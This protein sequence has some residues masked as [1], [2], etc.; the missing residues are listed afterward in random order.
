MGFAV[1]GVLGGDCFGF[2]FLFGFLGLIG[3][4]GVEALPLLEETAFEVFGV[5]ALVGLEGG[6]EFGVWGL[7]AAGEG[8]RCL[9]P[10]VGNSLGDSQVCFVAEVSDAVEGVFPGVVSWC[11]R[12]GASEKVGSGIGI[13][14]NGV[15]LAAFEDTVDGVDDKDG[16]SGVVVGFASHDEGAGLNGVSDTVFGIFLVWGVE[17]GF[18]F[19]LFVDFGDSEEQVHFS[20]SK[21]VLLFPILKEHDILRTRLV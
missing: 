6:L 7:G 1:G 16:V 3:E 15:C 5:V 8:F 12:G 17:E 9:I 18:D 14:V 2:G 21:G 4:V 19:G 11:A 20:V 10:A 13:A